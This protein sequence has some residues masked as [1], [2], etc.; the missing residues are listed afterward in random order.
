MSQAADGLFFLRPHQ[1]DI[2]QW[3]ACLARSPEALIYAQAWYLDAV[4]ER[5]SAVVERKDGQY[6]SLLPLPEKRQAGLRQIYQPFFTQQLG[7]FTTPDSR[8]TCP[9]AYLARIPAGYWRVYL[10]LNTHNHLPAGQLVK[11]FAVKARITY[12]LALDQ[13][14]EKLYQAYRYNQ[15]RNIRKGPDDYRVVPGDIDRLIALFRENKGAQVPEL[16][17]KD[18]AGLGRLY[19]ELHRRGCG[20]V[21]GLQSGEQLL[22]AGLFVDSRHHLIYLFG[23]STAAGRRQAAMAKLLDHVIRQQAGSARVLDFE[24][25]DMPSLAKFY[26]NFGA[27]PVPY[28]SLNRIRIPFL[29]PWLKQKF[30]Y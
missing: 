18:Y 27:R 3:E 1:V 14:Y 15:K 11:G 12:H 23:A 6:V 8:F 21:L 7:L 5:W 10:Q 9:G 22:A 16:Q 19:R 13:P 20:Q 29:A 17:Q 25:S 26:A 2:P 24:G 4:C 28:L 30:L